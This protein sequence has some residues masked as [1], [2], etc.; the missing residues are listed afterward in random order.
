M[1]PADLDEVYTRLAN[2]IE[3]SGPHSE[4][5]LAMLVLRLAGASGDPRACLDAISLTLQDLQRH[6]PPDPAGQHPK[7]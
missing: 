6:E 2:A 3:A 5:F 4:L 7:P 1:T